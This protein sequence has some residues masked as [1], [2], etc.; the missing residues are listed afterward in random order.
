[1][2]I[3]PIL[4]VAFSRDG[5]WLASGSADAMVCLWDLSTPDP[6]AH[7]W[8][9]AG[10]LDEIRALSFSPDGHWLASGSLDRTARLWDIE[11]DD[12]YHQFPGVA[13]SRGRNSDPCIQPEQ[14]LVGYR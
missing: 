7:P 2:P 6:A 4:A 5:R 12:P 10:H 1:M 8:N 3:H 13:R 11:Q 9:M 14:P